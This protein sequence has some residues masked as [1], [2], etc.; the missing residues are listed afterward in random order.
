MNNRTTKFHVSSNFV[1]NFELIPY[2]ALTPL[3]AAFHKYQMNF[4]F[5]KVM[6]TG[7]YLQ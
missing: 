5:W 4:L 2:S 3:E 6:C 7:N 1:A